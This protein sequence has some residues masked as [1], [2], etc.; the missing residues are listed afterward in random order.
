MRCLKFTLLPWHPHCG[1]RD[2]VTPPTSANDTDAVGNGR[3]LDLY[4]GT[5]TN[6]SQ[7]RRGN[8]GRLY[9]SGARSHLHMHTSWR[10]PRSTLTCLIRLAL[11]KWPVPV[12]VIAFLFSVF[13]VFIPPLL[14]PL[15]FFLKSA[16]LLFPL[17]SITSPTLHRPAGC[18]AAQIPK[19]GIHCCRLKWMARSFCIN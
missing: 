10:I 7:A 1:A 9:A 4:S 19:Y 12:T 5:A 6:D 14:L 16:I 8:S 11:H 17:A 18:S 15:P 3:Q 2:Q 13:A